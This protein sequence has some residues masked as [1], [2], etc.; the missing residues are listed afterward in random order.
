L[1]QI[2][3]EDRAFNRRRIANDDAPPSWSQIAIA[4]LAAFAFVVFIILLDGGS[5]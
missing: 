3:D 4:A 1:R 5:L 2:F